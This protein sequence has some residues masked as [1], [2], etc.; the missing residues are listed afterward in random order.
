MVLSSANLILTSMA[1]FYLQMAKNLGCGTS[2][3]YMPTSATTFE[4]QE[5][6]FKCGPSPTLDTSENFNLSRALGIIY[7][8]QWYEQVEQAAK[9]NG[10]GGVGGTLSLDDETSAGESSVRDLDKDN[11]VEV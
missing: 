2:P 1:T 10:C 8:K 3:N 7:P 4:S 11:R 5:G 6:T 9:E